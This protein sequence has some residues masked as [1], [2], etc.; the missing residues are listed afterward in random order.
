MFP[1]HLERSSF[2]IPYLSGYRVTPVTY[3]GKAT[4]SYSIVTR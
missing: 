3:I 4:H 2:Q 1:T